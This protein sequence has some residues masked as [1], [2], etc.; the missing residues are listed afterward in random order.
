MARYINADDI[1]YYLDTSEY[2]PMEGRKITFK[3]DIDK[4]PT[5]DVSEVK[6]GK[7][8]EITSH[9]GCTYDYDC[10]CSICGDDGLPYDAYCSNCGAKMDLEEREEEWNNY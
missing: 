7:W 2:A 3:S 6:H 5:A 10:V 1:P 4:V 8:E 9:N